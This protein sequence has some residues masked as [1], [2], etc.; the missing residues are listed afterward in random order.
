MMTAVA[1]LAAGPIPGFA[2]LVVGGVFLA[3]WHQKGASGGDCRL[4]LSA[5]LPSDPSVVP[6]KVAIARY[7]AVRESNHE[8]AL[9]LVNEGATAYDIQP[10]PIRLPKSMLM[11]GFIPRLAKNETAPSRITIPDASTPPREILEWAIGENSTIENFITSM[12]F[13]ITYRDFDSNWYSSVCAIDYDIM[14]QVISTRFIRQE[15]VNLTTG[16]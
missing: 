3:I 5:N 2:L 16:R 15:K 1:F 11:F 9:Y 14:A 4:T 6:P 12:E 7:G 13:N 10:E 8:P